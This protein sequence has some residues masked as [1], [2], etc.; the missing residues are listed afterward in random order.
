MI[1]Q[2]T[3]Y[4]VQQAKTTPATHG[5]IISPKPRVLNVPKQ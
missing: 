2:Y 5:N 4:K 3:L 1:E